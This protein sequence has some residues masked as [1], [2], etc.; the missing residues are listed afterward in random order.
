MKANFLSKE[1]KVLSLCNDSFGI[2]GIGYDII[3]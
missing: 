2:F 1:N 3:I